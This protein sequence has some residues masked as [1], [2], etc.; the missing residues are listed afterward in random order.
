MT[1]GAG[2]PQL[3]DAVV[4]DS[5][6]LELVLQAAF[7]LADVRRAVRE[8]VHPLERLEA[9]DR[10]GW[11]RLALRG[12]VT[13]LRKRSRKRSVALGRVLA[14]PDLGREIRPFLR[15]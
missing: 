12:G 14:H 11:A 10:S 4:G 7:V 8:P 5:L 1:A 6:V 2:E 13:R 3:L 9:G 15:P